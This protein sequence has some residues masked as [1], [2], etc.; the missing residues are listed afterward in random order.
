MQKERFAKWSPNSI[1][2]TPSIGSLFD[3]LGPG[4]GGI[5]GGGP[6]SLSHLNNVGG[7][8][9]AMAR[10][11]QLGGIPGDVALHQV[12]ALFASHVDWV[13][14]LLRQSTGGP[15]GLGGIGG[16]GPP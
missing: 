6:S 1:I 11:L 16:D 8:P 10:V 15:G 5:G 13:L 12:H 7:R 2:A 4:G 9:R 14:Y 3:G